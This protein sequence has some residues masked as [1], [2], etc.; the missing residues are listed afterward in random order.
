MASSAPEESWGGTPTTVVW[1]SSPALRPAQRVIRDVLG[2]TRPSG[3]RH[4]RR[5]RTGRA[6]GGVGAPEHGQHALELGQA[7]AAGLLG[8]LQGLLRLLG[9]GLLDPPGGRDLDG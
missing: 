4:G 7:L 9:L 3:G 2:E 5:P 1:T 6:D 8:R